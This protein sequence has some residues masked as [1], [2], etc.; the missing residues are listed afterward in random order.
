MSKKPIPLTAPDVSQFARQ[1]T[2]QLKE[3]A[4]PPSHLSVM[5]MLARAAGFRNYQHM[6]AAHAARGRMDEAPPQQAADFRLVERTLNQFDRQG[7][8]VRWPS[9]RPV[10]ELCLWVFWA[11]LPPATPLPEKKVNALLDAA[12]LFGD[13]AILRRSMIGLGLV[14]RNRD[15]S[16]YRRQEKRPPVEA[17][18]LIRRVR[19]RRKAAAA[20]DH[21]AWRYNFGRPSMRSAGS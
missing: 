1:L 15:G 10:Q 13:A 14:T 5:N 9:R 3:Q 18:E 16:N 6:R 4:D 7:R 8:L 11:D 2:R 21:A 12:H 19:T 17:R 20:R